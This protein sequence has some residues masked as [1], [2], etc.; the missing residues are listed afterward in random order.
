MAAIVPDEE[1]FSQFTD[2]SRK[3]YRRMWAQLKDYLSA[4]DFESGPPG[5]EDFNNFFKFLR[6]EKKF[7]SSSLWTWYS[8]LNSMVKRNYNMKLQD[9]PRLTM[10]IKG[11]DT[12]VKD[13]AEVFQDE[14][15]KAFMLGSMED[16][17]WLVRQAI[18]IVAFFGGLRLSECMD[19]LLE[20]MVRN[21]DGYKITHNRVKQQS[22]QRESAFLVPA[23]DG[24][25][26]RL[27]EYLNK[28]NTHL[29]KFTGR[30]W[31]TGT[32]GGQQLKNQPM[33]RNMMGK[34]PHDLAI[35]LRVPNP[36]AYTFHSY[37]RS[38]ATAA[39]N[40]GKTAE[41]MLPFFGWKNASMVQEYISTSR[42]AI[43]NM[44]EALGTVGFDLEDPVI[45]QEA[46]GADVDGQKESTVEVF[47]DE[48]FE[49]EE[50]PEMYQAAGLPLPCS[51]SGDSSFSVEKTVHQAISSLPELDGK[52][53]T[54]KVCFVNQNH[55]TINMNM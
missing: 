26:D 45:E 20:K 7:A 17:Y 8:C 50:D 6:M 5:E 42:P 32:K 49:M 30:V 48:T 19:L 46:A 47:V 18:S 29:K 10:L 35:R 38:S 1:V 25:A 13:K 51:S 34:V 53:I 33:G 40:G 54:V 21:Q 14:H 4:F 11:Y 22:D 3:Q 31:W 52:N 27:S 15:L 9:F 39:A 23:K 36:A 44:A 2:D 41:Q 16:S 37:R 28:V 24:F 12:D 55:G 43:V